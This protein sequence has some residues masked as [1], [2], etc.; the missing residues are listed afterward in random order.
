VV[1][2]KSR[3]GTC[4]PIRTHLTQI[5]GDNDCNQK[6]FICRGRALNSSSVLW[7]RFVRIAAFWAIVAFFVFI[8]Q[9]WWVYFDVHLIYKTI[10]QAIATG[11]PDGLSSQAFAFSLA[12]G[13]FAVAISLAI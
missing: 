2:D 12:A 4:F 9:V 11:K 5:S 1:C 7:N 8:F 6:T 10:V 13:I 3:P